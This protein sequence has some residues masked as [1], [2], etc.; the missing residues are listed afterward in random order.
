MNEISEIQREILVEGVDDYFGLWEVVWI[1]RRKHPNWTNRQIRERSLEV[2]RPLLESAYIV[3]GQLGE[4]G[5]YSKWQL[6]PVESLARIDHEWR[7]LGRD[8]N[9]AQICWFSN[10]EKGD[11]AARAS[12][13]SNE[14]VPGK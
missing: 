5:S 3:A 8:P 2:L 1:L 4:S 11:E 9:M 13:E 6:G 14:W 12:G 7:K 10:T